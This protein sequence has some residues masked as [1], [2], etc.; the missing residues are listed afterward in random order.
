MVGRLFAA[1]GARQAVEYCSRIDA[2]GEEGSAEMDNLEA[3]LLEARHMQH[4]MPN[5][6]TLQPCNMQQQCHVRRA[7]LLEALTHCWHCC[8]GMHS[9]GAK[10]RHGG[11]RAAL[12]CGALVYGHRKHSPTED[13]GT[14]CV[15]LCAA[16]CHSVVCR[17]VLALQKQRSTEAKL[18]R[19]KLELD[20]K[21]ATCAK[22]EAELA[23]LQVTCNCVTTV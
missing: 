17:V 6:A 7:I 1:L 2:G 19:A 22:L 5:L 14:V 23:A 12:C 13:G 18:T 3:I 11:V 20:E 10:P 15:V 8:H 9:L 16:R 21:S 4:A